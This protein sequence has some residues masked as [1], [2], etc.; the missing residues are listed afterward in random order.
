MLCVIKPTQGGSH[1]FLR[2]EMLKKCKIN[3]GPLLH[4]TFSSKFL[5]FLQ[6]FQPQEMMRSPLCIGV[7]ES[8]E[9]VESVTKSLRI[10]VVESTESVA[11][12]QMVAQIVCRLADCSTI[13]RP[14]VKARCCRMS[15][16]EQVI[17]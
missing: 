14:K 11:R 10:I 12:Y 17:Q 4:R 16:R 9:S 13:K 3:F 7:V 2:L 5:A 8:V 15:G 1:H 6:H